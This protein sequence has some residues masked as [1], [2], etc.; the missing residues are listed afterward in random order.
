MIRRDALSEYA[1]GSL[2]VL[3]TLSVAGA[4]AAIVYMNSDSPDVV[5]MDVRAATLPAVSIDNAAGLDI[6]GGIRAGSPASNQW[7]CRRR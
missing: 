4:L 3:P 7:I 1:Q 2:W 5:T 6:R